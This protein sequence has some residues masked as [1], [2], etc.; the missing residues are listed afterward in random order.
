MASGGCPPLFCA[1]RTP[2]KPRQIGHLR[3]F[4]RSHLG[5]LSKSYEITETTETTETTDADLHKRQSSQSS[6]SSQ[7]SH[8]LS[9]C[10]GKTSP[11]PVTLR[12][13]PQCASCRER[14][15]KRAK[16]IGATKGMRTREARVLARPTRGGGLRLPW[17]RPVVSVV[18]VDSVDSVS[19]E[20]TGLLPRRNVR[21][22]RVAVRGVGL[23]WVV[24]AV[25]VG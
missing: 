3:A 5:H 21:F 2:T 16:G 11:P 4:L 10:H 9:H 23:P 20:M 1:H 24:A 22:V 14:R 13:Q 8:A 15:T 12:H 25:H 18:S 6:Q 7:W 17:S 19:T